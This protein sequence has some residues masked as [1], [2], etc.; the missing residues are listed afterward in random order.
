MWYDGRDTVS[1]TKYF[2]TGTCRAAAPIRTFIGAR[3]Q[4]TPKQVHGG[5]L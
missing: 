1:I 5:L 4:Y 3:L 2:S